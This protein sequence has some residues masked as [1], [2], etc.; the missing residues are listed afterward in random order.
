VKPCSPRIDKESY[1]QVG[2][3]REGYR[4]CLLFGGFRLSFARCDAYDEKGKSYQ[5]TD[6]RGSGEIQ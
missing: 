4:V 3:A 1:T 5:N 6:L 2:S